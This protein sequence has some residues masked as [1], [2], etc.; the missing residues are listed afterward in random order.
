M[1]ALDYGKGNDALFV[2]MVYDAYES[3]AFDTENLN[4]FVIVNVKTNIDQWA[5]Q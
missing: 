3:F 2:K 1:I 5:A 4:H